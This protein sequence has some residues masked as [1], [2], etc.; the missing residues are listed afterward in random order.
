MFKSNS[1]IQCVDSLISLHNLFSNGQEDSTQAD[2]IREDIEM[3]WDNLLPLEQQVLDGL[4]GDLYMLN[5][6]SMYHFRTIGE[7]KLLRVALIT[8]IEKKDW[9][10]ILVLLRNNLDFP[11]ELI[12]SYRSSCWMNVNKKVAFMFL[13]YAETLQSKGQPPAKT[14]GK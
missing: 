13:K 4:S 11:E 8:A 14:R 9:K 1:F 2:Q 5:D 3:P 12:A 10:E 7:K 6:K